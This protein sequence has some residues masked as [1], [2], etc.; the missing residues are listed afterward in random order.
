[1]SVCKALT[2]GECATYW[3]NSVPLNEI[4]NYVSNDTADAR[5]Y[6]IRLA[7]GETIDM[8]LYGYDSETAEVDTINKILSLM[9]IGGFLAYHNQ[10]I[11]VPNKEVMKKIEALLLTPKMGNISRV[12]EKSKAL[13]NATINE[14]AETV[15]RL[16]DEAH[17]INSSYFTYSNENT[18][19]CVISIAY[20]AAKDNYNIKHEDNTGKGRTNFTF[21]PLNPT[22]TAFILELKATGSVQEALDQIKSRDYKT[23]LAPYRG[24]KLAVAICYDK[25][26]KDKKHSVIIEELD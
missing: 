5:P 4:T 3:G 8:E 12:L 20:F 11:F 26:S 14:D 24:K 18:L 15:A 22:D 17:S 19:S 6:I 9:V 25:D 10:Q 13:L 1:M 2:D 16:I 21:F 7:A 23:T